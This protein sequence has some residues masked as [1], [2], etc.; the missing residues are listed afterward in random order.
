MELE[1]WW[2]GSGLVGDE[3]VTLTLTLSTSLTGDALAQASSAL[4][5]GVA[6]A[7]HSVYQASLRADDASDLGVLAAADGYLVWC[8]DDTCGGDPIGA[9]TLVLDTADCA[10]GSGLG[11]RY[12][13]EANPTDMELGPTVVPEG[14]VL[15]EAVVLGV[16]P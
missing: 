6:V 7:D 13:G 14:C 2:T 1:P 11:G 5:Q 16:G 4:G 8:G 15:P 9:V 10:V 12:E 3:E